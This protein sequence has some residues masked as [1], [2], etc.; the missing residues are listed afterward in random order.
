MKVYQFDG[1]LPSFP[2]PVITVGTFDGVHIGH[3][4]IIKRLNELAHARNGESVLLTFHPHPR[5]VLNPADTDLQL[6][7]TLDEKIHWLDCYGLDNVVI[8]HFSKSFSQTTPKDYIQYVLVDKFSPE[9]V[10]IG[11]DHHFGRTA[12]VESGKWKHSAKSSAIR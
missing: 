1:Q 6:L 11:Y 4:I 10:V 9:V 12:P 5:L 2:H 7:N 3:Q 8:A